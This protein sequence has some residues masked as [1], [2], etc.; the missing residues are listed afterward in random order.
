MSILRNA[1]LVFIL[2]S[3]TACQSMK[4][5][6]ILD[7]ESKDEVKDSSE[8]VIAAKP[9]DIQTD[10]L[11]DGLAKEVGLKFSSVDEQHG[12]KALE[13]NYTNQTSE[14]IDEMN[15]VVLSV[16]PTRTFIQNDAIHCRDYKAKVTIGLRELAINAVAC[17]QINGAWV[18]QP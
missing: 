15:K 1:G 12:Q 11:L 7:S 9:T 18:V 13:E 16:T 4:L 14:W 8:Q 3:L 17:R 5:G 2:L 10:K 6:T